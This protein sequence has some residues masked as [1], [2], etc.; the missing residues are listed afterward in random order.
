MRFLAL[1]TALAFSVGAVS[2]AQA[3]PMKD[4][5]AQSGQQQIV[6][7]DKA[8]VP[9]TPIVIPEKAEKSEG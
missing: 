4:E 8:K 2:M 7:S 6:A 5:V 1:A 9:S 3:C